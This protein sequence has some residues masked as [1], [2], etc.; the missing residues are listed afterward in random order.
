MGRKS[1]IRQALGGAIS[2]LLLAG[3]AQAASFTGVTVL[4]DSIV[5]TGNAN[6]GA[7]FIGA[8]SP[9]PAP[10]YFDGRFANGFNYAD[11]ISKRITNAPATALLRSTNILDPKTNYATGGAGASLNP[12]QGQGI[13]DAIP[14]LAEQTDLYINGGSIQGIPFGSGLDTTALHLI[15]IGGNDFLAARAGIVDPAAIAAAAAAAV[16][17]ALSQLVAAGA[18][19]ILVSNVTTLIALGGATP[20]E[21]VALFQGI[22]AYNAALAQSV[23]VLNAADPA[24]NII[25]FDNDAIT[26]AI[27]SD[28][29]AFGFDPNL[30]G[31][32]CVINPV[33]LAMDCV[34]YTDFDGVHPTAAVQRIYAD[35]ALE[36]LGIAPVPVPAA[37]PL[38]LAGLALVGWKRR[39]NG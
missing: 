17:A 1:A 18:N 15:N 2:A 38:M 31:Q 36:A 28:P 11:L 33:A 39:K 30:V 27:L 16:D 8:P 19:Q 32:P 26:T 37:A 23:A 10:F 21:Q 3:A 24:N 13:P 20:Q 29:A 7:E 34:G 22:S 14:D 9:T 12:Y 5:D 25:I 35:V 6:A 4:G